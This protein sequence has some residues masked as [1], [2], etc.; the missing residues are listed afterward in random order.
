MILP[1]TLPDVLEAEAG[2]GARLGA[3]DADAAAERTRADYG[4]TSRW[5][6]GLLGTA[7]AAVAV[8]ITSF[9]IEVLASGADPLG[10]AVF[11]AFVI[12]VAAAFGVPSIVLLV[13]LHR[14]GRRLARAAAYWAEL[15]YAH[16]RRAPGRGDWF[17][18][19]FAGYS[20][21][22]LPRLITSSLAGLAAVFA[23]SAAIRALVIAA[24]VS[25]TALW[26][27]WAVLFACVCCGQFGGVQRI[28]NG[29][30]AREPA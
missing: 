6:L 11:A 3:I 24:P 25:Q 20:G 29:L 1:A 27:G 23:A 13:G 18:V 21:D 8:L 12:L 30:L 4:R 15:P 16:G 17:A 5:A 19:R 14:S 28:Q 7:G 22:L 2:T 10:D 9:A 26:A